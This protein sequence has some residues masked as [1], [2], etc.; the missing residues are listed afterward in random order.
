MRFRFLATLI[1][2][3]AALPS[4]TEDAIVPGRPRLDVAAL[5]RIAMSPAEVSFTAKL[6]G[7]GEME[8]FHCPEVEW[9]WAD[10]AR[11]VRLSDCDP[12]QPGDE[13]ARV[14]T[15]RHRF[16]HPGLY[17]VTVNLRRASRVVAAANITIDVQAGFPGRN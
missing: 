6:V 13:V 4:G 12:Y 2:L 9:V 8:D 10:G 3:A 14:F 5:P 17:L 7:E 11:S 15:A 1:F 16:R